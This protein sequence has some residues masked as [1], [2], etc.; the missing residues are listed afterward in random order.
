VLLGDPTKAGDV[1]VQ[2]VKLPAHYKVPPHTHLYTETITVL[3][4]SVGLRRTQR[5]GTSPHANLRQRLAHYQ[6]LR[7]HC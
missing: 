6:L 5:C 2:R 1:I 4:A 3:S 7:S